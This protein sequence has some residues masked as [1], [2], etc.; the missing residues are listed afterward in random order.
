MSEYITIARPYAKAIFSIAKRDNSFNEWNDFLKILFDTIN[1]PSFENFLKNRTISFDDKSKIINEI[2]ELNTSFDKGLLS[3]FSKFLYVL[4]YYGRLLCIKDIYILYK[5][6]M[7][8]ELS[9]IEAI[10]KVPYSISNSQKDNIMESLS[11][12]FNKKVSISFE[13]DEMLLGGFLVKVGDF[14]LDASISGNLTS[15]S[16]KI[17]L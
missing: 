3:I 15:L 17:I 10:V 11:K 1:D 14:V 9:C 13:I 6:Y 2:I 4:A 5:K 16:T 7:N 8:I 12:R